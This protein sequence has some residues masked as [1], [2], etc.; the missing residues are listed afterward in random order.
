MWQ[1]K[2]TRLA[3]CVYWSQNNNSN[4]NTSLKKK[5]YIRKHFYR[6]DRDCGIDDNPV[7]ILNMLQFIMVLFMFKWT[8]F[9]TNETLWYDG[10][11]MKDN[12]V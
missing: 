7:Y 3:E 8:K 4:I 9:I 2:K 10:K 1:L 11:A 6:G 12:P 5:I